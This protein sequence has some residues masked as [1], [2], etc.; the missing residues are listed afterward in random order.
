[1]DAKPLTVQDGDGRRYMAARPEAASHLL[2]AIS[3]IQSRFIEK[4]SHRVLLDSI[5]GSLMRLTDSEYGFLGDLCRQPDGESYFKMQVVSDSA[6]KGMGRDFY[7]RHAPIGMEFDETSWM[8]GSA[9]RDG[10]V[11]IRNDVPGHLPEGHLPIRSFLGLPIASGSEVLGMVGLANGES[12]YNADLAAFLQPLLATCGS[13]IKAWR[14]DSWRREVEED[15]RRH[16]L[17][18]ENIS[19]GVILT[20][21]DGM[22]LDCNRAAEA[23]TGQP[24]KKLIGVPL[25]FIVEAQGSQL[26]ADAAATIAAEGCW[27]GRL[28]MRRQDGELRI[29]ESSALRL[30]E[31]AGEESLLAWFHRDITEQERA[32]TKLAQRTRELNVILDLSPVGFVFIDAA[33]QVAYANPAFAQMSGLDTDETIG[34]TGEEFDQVLAVR[35]GDPRHTPP[36]GD[37]L[38]HL[39]LPRHAT[40]RRIRRSL[41]DA[42]GAPYGQVLCFQDITREAEVD[43]LKSE[44]LSTAAHEL[45][46]PMASVFGFSELLL[47][48]EIEPEKQRQF[49]G[50]IHR[51]AGRLAAIINELLDLTRI[52]AM[53]GKDFK[54]GRHELAPLIGQVVDE[55]LVPGDERQVE[56]TL[57]P[58]LPPVQI[59]PAKLH[60]ALTNVLSNAYKYSFGKG[61]IALEACIGTGR[62]AGWLGL[63]VRDEGIGM[64]A[65]QLGQ[66]FDRFWRADTSGKVAGTGLGM[67]LVKEI[68]GIFKGSVEI[69]SHPGRGTLVTL[70]L[71]VATQ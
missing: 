36:S 20:D 60:L 44:F 2:E 33:G 40:L 61:R 5:L 46:T 41:L 38:L 48:R 16:A 11:V 53:E 63:A 66:V 54:I 21:H 49:I 59:D 70:W 47:N 9:L 28:S 68:I 23:M 39:V 12:G 17:V 29:Y 67:S 31:I 51:Q 18:F 64:S 50:V 10:Q 58:Q 34:M 35:S 45:R 25:D 55:L 8:F 26:V 43:R 7:E 1:M 57:P 15:L 22:I 69:D 14:A 13:L 62:H 3:A 6:W 65:D 42:T 52:E 19:D 37:D 71:P 30:R 32:H 4:A 56:V 27:T 24:R